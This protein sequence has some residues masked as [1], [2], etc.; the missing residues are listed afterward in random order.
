M[1]NSKEILLKSKFCDTC[2]EMC[3]RFSNSFYCRYCDTYQLPGDKE[4][5]NT[6]FDKG[7]YDE[8]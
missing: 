4:H 6:D 5:L 2:C 3:H 7:E 1:T 8:N